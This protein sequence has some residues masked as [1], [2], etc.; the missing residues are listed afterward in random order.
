MAL[1]TNLLYYLKK[2][3]SFYKS[4]PLKEA[5]LSGVS[6]NRSL[7]YFFGTEVVG[8]NAELILYV[9]RG[10]DIHC[11]GG[12][13][14]PRRAKIP[15]FDV[16]SRTRSHEEEIRRGQQLVHSFLRSEK[17][18]NLICESRDEI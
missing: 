11:D 12:E 2:F 7:L 4:E 8:S 10:I 17:I 18:Y 14:V 6:S 13:I 3:T 5:L 16:E 9:F 1:I 15:Q